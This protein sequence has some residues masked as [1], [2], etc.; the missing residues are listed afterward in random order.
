MVE[1]HWHGW[2]IMLGGSFQRLSAS[3]TANLA[4]LDLRNIGKKVCKIGLEIWTLVFICLFGGVKH[5]SPRDSSCFFSNTRLTGVPGAPHSFFHDGDKP[6]RAG[7][8]LYPFFERGP[9]GKKGW[10]ETNL[11]YRD[12]CTYFVRLRFTRSSYFANTLTHVETC[13]LAIRIMCESV[14]QKCICVHS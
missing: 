2:Y 5:R 9:N 8:S 4:A 6:L 11:W 3:S 10:R 13:C 12:S 14:S 7:N 1:F